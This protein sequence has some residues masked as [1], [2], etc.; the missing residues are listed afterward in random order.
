MEMPFGKHQGEEVEE[1]PVSYLRWILRNVHI[2]DDELREEIEERVGEPASAEPSEPRTTSSSGWKRTT[3]GPGVGGATSA[4]PR[5]GVDLDAVARD[6]F[7][8]INRWRRKMAATHHP[9]K[10]GDVLVMQ[11]V[12]AAGDVLLTAIDETMKRHR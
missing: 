7:D 12:N 5:P 1:I 11:A 4:P 8:T 3:G 10:G 2:R 9:D 6:L